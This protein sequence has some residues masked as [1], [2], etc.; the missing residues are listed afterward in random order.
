MNQ[1]YTK[2]EKL[3]VEAVK[4]L[5]CSVCDMPAPSEAH[6][7]RQDNPYTLVA[8]CTECHRGAHDGWHGKKAI[9]RVKKM[10]ELDALAI[11]FKRL[12]A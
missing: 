6:H 10:D 11:T 12:L 8:L 2:A 5:P 7:I 3:H 9:W 4:S 1:S